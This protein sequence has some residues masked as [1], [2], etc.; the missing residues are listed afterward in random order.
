MKVV[1]EYFNVELN[2]VV[3]AAKRVLENFD[4]VEVAVLIGSVLRRDFV[5]DVDIGLITSRPLTMEEL[6]RVASRLEAE[7]G[8]PVD[9]V[10]LDEAP[11]LLRYKALAEGVKIVVKNPRIYH[12]TLSESLME[13][14]DMEMKM[15]MM[16][17][18]I[19]KASKN[20]AT[21]TVSNQPI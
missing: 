3:E 11:P 2:K 19:Q 16:K 18:Y 15:K 17:Q 5:R 9:L 20:I 8:V 7:I 12:Y 4:V 6:N 13:L 10:P 14:Q 21:E 1:V